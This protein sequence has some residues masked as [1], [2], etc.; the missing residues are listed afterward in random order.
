MT[1]NPDTGIDEDHARE[2]LETFGRTFPQ[3]QYIEASLF[4]TFSSLIRG[5]D[6][7]V[8]SAAYHS[9]TGFRSR[10]GMIHDAINVA[11][12]GRDLLTEWKRLRKR[13]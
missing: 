10:L 9:V 12:D 2:F 6:H 1:N 13:I 8:V 11:L 5:R 7:H 4:L 3:W